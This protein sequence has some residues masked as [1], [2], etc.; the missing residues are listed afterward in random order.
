[1]KEEDHVVLEI[2]DGLRLRQISNALRSTADDFREL[3]D[4]VTVL[5]IVTDASGFPLPREI[6]GAIDR[7]R[8][9]LEKVVCP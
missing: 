6:Q 3:T 7:V 8:D 9:A 2:C 1:M 4:A 5:L